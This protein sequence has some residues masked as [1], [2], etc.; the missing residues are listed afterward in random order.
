MAFRDTWN[1]FHPVEARLFGGSGRQ[2]NTTAPRWN[3][4][5]PG[6]WEMEGGQQAPTFNPSPLGQL[7]QRMTGGGLLPQTQGQAFQPADP[8]A[9]AGGLPPSPMPQAPGMMTGGPGQ[10]FGG[11]ARLTGGGLPPMRGSSFGAP[12]EPEPYAQPNPFARFLRR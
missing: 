10:S 4:V 6:R 8:L 5:S 7:G 1:T 9:T 2:P 3:E 12:M 11:F